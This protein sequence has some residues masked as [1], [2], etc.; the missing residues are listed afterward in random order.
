VPHE[1][2]LAERAKVAD[3]GDRMDSEALWIGAQKIYFSLAPSII[4]YGPLYI[5]LSLYDLLLVWVCWSLRGSSR[6]WLSSG[7]LGLD[8]AVNDQGLLLATADHL[9]SN[10]L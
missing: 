9:R 1:S 7:G 8:G 10:H 4:L 6:R 3:L 5:F 2:K